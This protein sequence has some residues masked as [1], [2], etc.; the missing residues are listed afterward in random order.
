MKLKPYEWYKNK[1]AGRQGNWPVKLDG[2]VATLPLAVEMFIV[3]KYWHLRDRVGIKK[4]Y[5]K[6]LKEHLQQPSSSE[7][8]E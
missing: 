7:S 1:Y 2:Q 6:K 4:V 5:Y 3:Q 8:I